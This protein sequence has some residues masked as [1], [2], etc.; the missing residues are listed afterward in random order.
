MVGEV[1]WNAYGLE[2]IEYKPGKVNAEVKRHTLDRQTRKII[3]QSA[4]EVE[5][6]S[7]A[8]AQLYS[9]QYDYLVIDKLWADCISLGVVPLEE[10]PG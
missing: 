1:P 2:G 3:P 4:R 6:R 10:D 9:A 8:E 7:E 5:K